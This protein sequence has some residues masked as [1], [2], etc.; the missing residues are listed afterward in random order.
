MLGP[1]DAP[2]SEM[3]VMAR[4]LHFGKQLARFMPRGIEW[5]LVLR[6]RGGGQRAFFCGGDNEKRH[7]ELLRAAAADEQ[8]K[9]QLIV[10]A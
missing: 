9:P 2:Q 7:R 1:D 8:S 3:D 6:L 10:E 5:C 4:V